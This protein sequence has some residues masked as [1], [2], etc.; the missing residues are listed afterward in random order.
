MSLLGRWS[1][2]IINDRNLEGSNKLTSSLSMVETVPR[3]KFSTS[4]NKILRLKGFNNSNK[5]VLSFPF[6]LLRELDEH[7]FQQGCQFLKNNILYQFH[8]LVTRT[9]NNNCFLFVKNISIQNLLT[10]KL[11]KLSSTLYPMYALRLSH[12]V[13]LCTRIYGFS[14]FVFRNEKWMKAIVLFRISGTLWEKNN[15]WI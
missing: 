9:C 8:L 7:T 10:D 12:D 1:Q 5:L 6:S 4:S 3:L 15:F 14:S 13:E 2:I 11:S